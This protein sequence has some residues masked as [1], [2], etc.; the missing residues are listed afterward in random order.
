MKPTKQ[1]VRRPKRKFI[2]DPNEKRKCKKMGCY[3]DAVT[4]QVYCCR[5]HAPYGYYGMKGVK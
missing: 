2:N 3:N 4:G 1:I 5:D